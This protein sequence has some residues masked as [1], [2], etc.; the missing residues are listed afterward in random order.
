MNIIES[1]LQ[2]RSSLY[3]DLHCFVC[4]KKF[5]IKHWGK[6]EKQWGNQSHANSTCFQGSVSCF[7]NYVFSDFNFSLTNLYG[8]F[9]MYQAPKYLPASDA[10]F[11]VG[12]A[13]TRGRTPLGSHP[14]AD[15]NPTCD[16]K[17]MLPKGIIPVKCWRNTRTEGSGKV[18][19]NRCN[20]NCALE[21]TRKKS[22]GP[23]CVYSKHF[24]P[25]TCGLLPP[26]HTH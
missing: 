10:T 24:W 9:M 3:G 15:T 17:L 11:M 7:Y 26:P 4:M 23:N 22:K 25:Q 12:A 20:S 14:A 16:L 6:R 8:S 18:A 13:R 21:K 1:I 5:E 2:A 19:G